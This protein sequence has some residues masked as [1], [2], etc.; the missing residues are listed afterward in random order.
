[1]RRVDTLLQTPVPSQVSGDF[2][3]ILYR[4]THDHCCICLLLGLD[5][6][7]LD[8]I[9]LPSLNLGRVHDMLTILSGNSNT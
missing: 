3:E 6:L 2:P 7:V 5:Y 1:M 9:L 8:H 4:S